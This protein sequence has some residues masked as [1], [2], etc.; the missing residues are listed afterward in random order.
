VG[1]VGRKELLVLPVSEEL[2]KLGFIQYWCN[3]I[4]GE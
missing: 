4:P 3:F 2:A 1:T